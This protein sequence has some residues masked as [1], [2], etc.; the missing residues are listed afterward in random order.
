MAEPTPAPNPP[1]P[2]Q[3][4]ALPS[5]ADATPYVPLSGLSVAALV[6]AGAFALALVAFG[7]AAFTNKKPLLEEWLLVLPVGAVALAFAARRV[8]RDSEGTRGGEGLAAGAWW[9]AVVLGLCYVAYLFAVDFAVRREARREADRWLELVQQ[10]T[11]EGLGTAFWRML[12]PGERQSLDPRDLPAIRARYRDPF[13]A[14]GNSD[15]VK[16]ARRN[17]N[18]LTY[19]HGGALWTARPGAMECGLVGRVSCPEGTFP[20][21][22][23]LKASDGVTA[24]DGAPGGPRQWVVVRPQGA[25]GFVDQSRA[26]RTPYGWL[27]QYLEADGAS[28]GRAFVSFAGNG[29]AAYP[30]VYRAFVAPDDG[31]RTTWRT[32]ASSA[33]AQLA[34]APAFG[35]TGRAPDAGYAEFREKALFRLPGGGEPSPE[36]RATFLRVWDTF[37]VRPAGDR[38]REGSG[39][40]PLDKDDVLTLTEA[41]VEVRV[42]AEIP[43]G[44]REA[45]RAKV[46]VACSDPALLAELSALRGGANPKAG[47]AAPPS[48]LGTRPFP[49]RVVRVESDLVPISVQPQGPG[50]PG[51]M[52]G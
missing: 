14:F 46:V 10:G 35:A 12:S 50:G 26:A 51:G 7:I 39:G 49:W 25:T 2:S 48:E 42:P 11:E 30:Y 3:G 23:M 19:E 34:F 17:P 8:I 41:G 1:V 27:L 24:A 40:T 13:H 33:V 6:A 36:Q 15:L 37:G 38:L 32:L 44:N 43:L 4:P 5:T 45:A 52:G 29:P 31:E 18:G 16:L 21:S 22:I 28:F 9:L 20:V 47:T